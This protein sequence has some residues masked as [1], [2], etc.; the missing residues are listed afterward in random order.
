[1]IYPMIGFQL[2]G[3]IRLQ[4]PDGAE[5]DALLRQPKR[6]ALLAYLV[7]PI[8]GTWHRRD[9]LLAL[10]WPELDT[11][12][13]RTSLRNAL[14]VLRQT[15]GDDVLRTRGD[16]EISVDPAKLKTDLGQVW[17]ALREGRTEDALANYRGELLPALF[18]SDSEGFQ[19]WLDTERARLKVEV[20][21]AALVLVGALESDG[22]PGEALSVAQRV[23][24]IQPDNETAV[25]RLMTLHEAM[26]DRAGALGV[27]ENYRTRLAS[28]F[29]AEPAPET[30]A[31]ANRLR[32]STGAGTPRPRPVVAN[33][34]RTTSPI[35]SV[36]QPEPG[37]AENAA[38]PKLDARSKAR[39][40][41][42]AGS[43]TL[44]L[45]LILLIGWE[46]S[47][48]PRPLS[49]GASAPLTSDQ[50]LQVEPAVSPN[51]RLVAYVK[52]SASRMRVF[53]QKIAGG[54]PWALTGDSTSVEIMPRWSPDNDELLFLSRNGAF[55]SPALGG[56][57]R[58]IAPGT[59]G[60]GSV[61]S[62][63]W[64]P[65]GDSVAIVRNDSLFVQP[66][67][68]SGSRFVGR[69]NQLHSCV[70]SPNGAWIACISGNWIA[71]VPGT[72]F[73]NRAPSGL[74]VYPA[75]GGAA[76]DV[77]DREKEH[78][79]P[80]WSEDG[81]VLWFLSNRDGV[82][83]EVYGVPIGRDGHAA[84][85]VTRAGLN[86]ESISL[87]AHRIAYSVP[88]RK[89]NI[90]SVRI[91]TKAPAT[92]AD[93]TPMTS[94]NQ[95]IELLSVSR[96]GKWLV[97]DSNLRGNSDIYRMPTAGGAAERLTDDPRQEFAGTLSPDNR[98]LAWQL[99]SN[100]E[101]HVFVKTLD[102]GSPRQVVPAP[103]D[104]GVPLWS[105]TG[106]SLVAWSHSTEQGAVFVVH[107]NTRGE[108][109]RP[110]WRLE[111]GQLPCWSPDGKT[112]AFVKFAGGI[113]TIPVD[114]GPRR[115]VYS[116]R[117]GTSDPAATYLGWGA[118]PAI[119]WFLGQDPRGHGGIWELRIRDG[120]ARPLVR[121]GDP[122]GRSN[123]AA[124]TTD[125]KRFFF[126]L[127]ERLS[128]VRWAELV[129]R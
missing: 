107:R 4:G 49:I 118:D 80:A 87:S 127:D 64:S 33:G 70:W 81:K 83:G 109:Q 72:L 51:G 101:R 95:V 2:L 88:V 129:N 53:V 61:R 89:Q 75:A 12:H 123:G 45:V 7:A 66:L 128:N 124:F 38:A 47:R 110:A 6:L 59:E 32:V 78:M 3:Q 34:R 94:G 121:F 25:R 96:D 40:R 71:F 112:I 126:T 125:G 91:P 43:A 19:R 82:S 97:Y 22:K 108:W 55:V 29:D 18:A 23:I 20:S 67:E 77:T 90:W 50:G 35:A 52:G 117:P 27:F 9:T 69:G 116:P 30:M 92:I 54:S 60:N 111:D 13:A 99:W 36:P 56:Q 74:I 84:G 86:A 114:S 10:F 106:S 104:Q 119:L 28:D 46:M 63:S 5:V 41:T 98:E 103:G 15:L 37:T 1:M 65:N 17:S 76:I 68:G 11:P 113:E 16:E 73:G 105:P 122:A 57:P 14:Y 100:G 48:P 93:A 26:G 24:E 102:G 79:S 120:H 58:L 39:F 85:P 8:P 42:A 31:L 21:K 44:I 62:A 115:T